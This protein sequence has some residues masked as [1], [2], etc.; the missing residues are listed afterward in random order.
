MITNFSN[1]PGIIEIEQTNS[2]EIGAGSTIAEIEVDLGNDQTFCGFPEYEII[3]QAPFGD[4]F[5]W[6]F[7]GIFLNGSQE[8]TITVNETGEYSV[9]VYDEQCGS[10]AEDS[11]LINLFPESYAYTPGNL[12]TC[13]DESLDGIENFDLTFQNQYILGDQDPS[14]Y[15]V[16]YYLDIEDAESGLNSLGTDFT[17]SI[18]PQQIFARVEHISSSVV[19]ASCYSLTTFNLEVSGAIPNAISPGEFVLCDSNN[20]SGDHQTFDLSS[21]NEIIL[22]GLSED[23]YDINFYLTEQDALLSVNSLE[24]MY[25][26]ISN[27]QTIFAR[28]ED[29]N[30]F[31]CFDIVSFD[32]SI[33]KIPE[34]ISPNNDGYNDTFELKGYNVNSIKIFNRYGKLVFSTNNYNNNW[35]GEGNNGEKLPVGTYFYYIMYNENKEKTGWVY[36]NY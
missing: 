30:T 24:S 5:E 8:N 31:E 22:N 14:E 21:Q 34:G 16:T 11:V 28:V 36:L 19:T 10:S 18:N 23:D 15:I 12:I 26:N 1:D 3:A 4:Y 17:N 35:K 32:I 2:G 7:N 29:K 27:P 33:C 9:I 25:D 13:D 6:Y 20:I